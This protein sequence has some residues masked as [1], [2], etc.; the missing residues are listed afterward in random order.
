MTP[1]SSPASAY[2]AKGDAHE[3]LPVVSCTSVGWTG[4]GFPSP[5]F[6]ACLV[7]GRGPG[8]PGHIGQGKDNLD[9]AV[10]LL[11]FLGLVA[12]DGHILPETSGHQALP[13]RSQLDELPSH[14]VGAGGAQAVVVAIQFFRDPERIGIGVTIDEDDHPGVRV[15]HDRCELG[16]GG[17]GLGPY[18]CLARAEQEVSVD[19]DPSGTLQGDDRRAQRPQRLGQLLQPRIRRR[20]RRRGGG[21]RPPHF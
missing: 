17:L 1:G 7:S 3:T 15:L 16:Q 13:G 12:G 10:P 9:P 20:P 4:W 19:A 8:H 6:P 5:E 21:A 14:G 2:R 11:A 18:V